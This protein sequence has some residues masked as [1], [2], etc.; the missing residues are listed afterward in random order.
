MKAI[1]RFEGKNIFVSI[2]TNSGKRRYSGK[3]IEVTFMGFEGDTE[4]FMF[5][6]IDK[7]GAYVSFT[8]KEI[9]YIEEEKP[10]E[11]R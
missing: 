6:I 5:T 9:E 1:K 7:F 11:A 4:I 8:N 10:R 2:N 3:C